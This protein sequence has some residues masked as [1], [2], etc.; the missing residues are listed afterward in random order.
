MGRISK[1]LRCDLH[2]HLG[3]ANVLADLEAQNGRFSDIYGIKE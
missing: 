1:G 2:Y 3:K